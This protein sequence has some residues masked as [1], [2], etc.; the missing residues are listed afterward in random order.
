MSDVHGRVMVTE[1]TE[2][3]EHAK[4]KYLYGKDVDE[5]NNNNRTKNNKKIIE[6]RFKKDT[7]H[8]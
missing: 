7:N 3:K 8:F 4:Y 2:G 1:D 6:F 5:N